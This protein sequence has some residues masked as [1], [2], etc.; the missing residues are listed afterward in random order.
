MGLQLLYFYSLT[1]REFANI[2]KGFRLRQET[3]YKNN[4]EI[5]RQIMWSSLAPYQQAGK[6]LSPQGIMVFPWEKEHSQA[7]VLSL[8]QI[9]QEVNTVNRAFW[10][11]IDAKRNK[12]PDC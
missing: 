12:L 2:A 6:K 1:P 10:E 7:D 3:D 9:E 5:A 11:R 8:E 4:W